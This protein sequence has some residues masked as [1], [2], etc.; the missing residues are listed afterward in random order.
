MVL[1][2]NDPYFTLKLVG[3]IGAILLGAAVVL[4]GILSIVAGVMP[5]FLGAGLL[6]TLSTMA[7]CTASLQSLAITS[8]MIGLLANLIGIGTIVSAIHIGLN[9]MMDDPISENSED[10]HADLTADKLH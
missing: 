1:V 8:I 4:A 2:T 3:T 5:L 9:A 6:I 7:A 10:F